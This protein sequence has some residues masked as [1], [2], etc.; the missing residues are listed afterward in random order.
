MKRNEPT[1]EICGEDVGVERMLGNER[2]WVWGCSLCLVYMCEIVWEHVCTA[3]WRMFKL[4]GTTTLTQTNYPVLQKP[5]AVHSSSVRGGGLWKRLPS[6]WWNE[7]WL[8][9]LE[10][11]TVSACPEDTGFLQPSLH[12]WPLAVF[13]SFLLW[14]LANII[15]ILP[16]P[17]V[18][19]YAWRPEKCVRSIGPWRRHSV[20]IRNQALVLWKSSKCS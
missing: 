6:P 15:S 14:W 7:A 20:G 2:G 1:R 9:L 10:V 16:A 11:T 13:V 3:C 17:Q 18:C 8:D 12:P 5:S 4:P 19:N